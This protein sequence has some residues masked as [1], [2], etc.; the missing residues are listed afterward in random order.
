VNLKNSKFWL[1]A[2]RPCSASLLPPLFISLP[3]PLPNSLS[4]LQPTFTRTSGHCL[5]TFIAVNLSV[6][7]PLNAVCLAIPPL[8]LLSLSFGFKG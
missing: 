6:F 4:C 2:V 1:N 7:P 3:S 8:S 5:G